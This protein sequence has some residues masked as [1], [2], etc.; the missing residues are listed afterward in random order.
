MKRAVLAGAAVCL[1]AYGA[2]ALSPKVE[3]A[4]K[5]FKGISADPGRTKTFCE[6]IQIMDAAAEKED[7][8]AEGKI[9]DLMKKLGPAF[10]AAWNAIDDIDENSEDAKAYNAAVDELAEKCS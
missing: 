5:T 4:V 6:M 3:S 2:L 9:S 10:E 1:G 8:A 7:A